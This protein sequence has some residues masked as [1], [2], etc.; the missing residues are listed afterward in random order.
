MSYFADWKEAHTF[1]LGEA[2]KLGKD[3][4]LEKWKSPLTPGMNFR[5]FGLLP[6]PEN[7]FGF[8]ARCEVVRPTD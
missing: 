3:M 7:R 4:G 5:V 6:K 8:E 2:R 1:A